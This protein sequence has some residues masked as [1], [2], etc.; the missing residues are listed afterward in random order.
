MFIAQLTDT[1]ITVPTKLG[2]NCNTKLDAL[3]KCVAAINKLGT[4]P[5]AIIHTGDLAHNGSVEE[6][7]ITKS[8]M[9]TLRAPYFITKGNRDSIKPLIQEF[10]LHQV[11]KENQSFLQ[12]S[13]NVL[14]YRLVAVDTSSKDSNLG[15][16][17][18]DRLADLD[19]ILA[20]EP[21]KSTLIFMHHPP[22]NLSDTGHHFYAYENSRMIKN[23]RDLM[24][25]HP[26]V[27][28]YFCGHIH[29][30][31]R[32]TI[33]LAPLVVMPPLCKTLNRE[34][35]S[36]ALSPDVAFYLHNFSNNRLVNTKSISVN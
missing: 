14:S 16:L 10:S 34:K 22:V 11:Q 25:R 33:N 28:A 21:H 7:Q 12:Y 13:A 18:F 4:L 24:V 3:R 36:K 8:I 5:D 31:F 1:H 9:D 17:N 23:F 19:K 20:E 32:S 6:Y 15:V 27:I 30:S 35:N 29:R 2:G 26:Q